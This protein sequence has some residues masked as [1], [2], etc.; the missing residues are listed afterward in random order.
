MANLTRFTKSLALLLCCALSSL[1]HAE[2]PRGYTAHPIET[3]ADYS[4][5]ARDAYAAGVWTIEEIEG[6]HATP[7][8]D[9]AHRQRAYERALQAFNE[10]I[11]A[12]PKMYEALTYV[13]YCERKLGRYEASLRAYAA[14]L[15][16]KPAY[17]YAIEYEGE[18]YLGLNDFARARFDYLRLYALDPALAAKLLAAMRKWTETTQDPAVAQAREWIESRRSAAH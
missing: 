9:E 17:V 8:T 5:R 18:A 3:G 13:G 10:A 6:E 12:E 2:K 11:A 7:L 1:A 14:A 4:Q 16:E 15:K